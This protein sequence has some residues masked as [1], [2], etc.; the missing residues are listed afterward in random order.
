MIYIRDNKFMMALDIDF[1]KN[2][3]G[4]TYQGLSFESLVVVIVI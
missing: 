3:R 2:F 4:S 1:L